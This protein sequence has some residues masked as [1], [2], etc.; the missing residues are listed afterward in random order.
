MKRD[1]R[2][3]GMGA[4]KSEPAPQPAKGQAP[5]VMGDINDAINQYGNKS[6]AE[7]M[8]ELV[9]IRRQGVIDD[10][11][12]VEVYQRLTPLLNDAQRKRLEAVLGTLQK[13]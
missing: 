10:E 9:N 4:N 13:S 3:L 12:L 6:E 7:L 2:G 11:K 1:L 8:N 5:P